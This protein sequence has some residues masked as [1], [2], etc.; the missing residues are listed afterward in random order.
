MLEIVSKEMKGTDQVDGVLTLVVLFLVP[1]QLGIRKPVINL[2]S[3]SHG[4]SKPV[5]YLPCY[6]P[7]YWRIIAGL[8]LNIN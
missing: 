7:W 4:D 5:R 1:F 3:V 8:Q 2:D 6:E